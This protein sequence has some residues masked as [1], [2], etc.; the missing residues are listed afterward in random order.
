MQEPCHRLAWTLDA[1][2]N[3]RKLDSK[4]IATLRSILAPYEVPEAAAQR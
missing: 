3:D 1:C 4:R 2:I